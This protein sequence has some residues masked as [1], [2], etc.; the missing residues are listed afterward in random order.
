MQTRTL[1]T[2]GIEVSALGFGCMGISFWYGPALS[3]SDGIAI[4]R[5]AVEAGVTLFD[6]AE[7][8]GPFINEEIVGEA[9]S[10]VREHV[11]IATKFGFR[12]EDGRMIG[13]DS[14]PAQIRQVADASLMRLRTDRIDLLYQHR[15]DPNVPIE[16]VAGTV[17]DLI[18][19]GKVQWWREPEHE[20]LP[21]LEQLGIGF[22]P[23]SRY[24]RGQD[25]SIV[26]PDHFERYSEGHDGCVR[27]S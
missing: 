25:D 14:R 20:I 8:Y 5:N 17:K 4:I 11:T 24:W 9:L 19:E 27:R 1:G 21:T 6:T 23:L 16:D 18:R 22:V 15:V 12:F 3:R 2:G 26:L 10:P 7:S 13:L